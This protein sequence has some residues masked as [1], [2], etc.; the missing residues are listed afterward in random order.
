MLCLIWLV[1]FSYISFFS[2]YNMKSLLIKMFMTLS[3][4]HKYPEKYI[5]MYLVII[6]CL[7][8]NFMVFKLC[9]LIIFS[10]TSTPFI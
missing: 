7:N 3:N 9:K 10:A 8:E 5:N 4:P 6:F 2:P 1:S